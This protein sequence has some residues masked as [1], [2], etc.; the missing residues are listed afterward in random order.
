MTAEE[1]DLWKAVYMEGLAKKLAPG[2][3]LGGN[4]VDPEALAADALK[5][6]RTACLL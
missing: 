6:F 3:G 5:A 1:F 2:Y 4:P